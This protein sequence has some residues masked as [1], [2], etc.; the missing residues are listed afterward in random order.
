MPGEDALLQFHYIANKF[1]QTSSA[2]G[3][4]DRYNEETAVHARAKCEIFGQWR[5]L[6]GE[7]YFEKSLFV[8]VY[9]MHRYLR[10]TLIRKRTRN[11]RRGRS[12]NVRSEKHISGSDH[13]GISV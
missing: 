3:F 5:S 10:I 9:M 4:D 13:G 2:G 1:S 12:S 8:W 7:Q 11:R 6:L